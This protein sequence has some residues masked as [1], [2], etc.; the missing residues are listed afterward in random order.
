MFFKNR[1][2]AG[3]KLAEKL[4]KYKNIKNGIVLGLP[5]GG[6][7]VAYEV[8]QVL[9]LPLDI[10]VP[11]KVG[12]PGQPELAVGAVCEDGSVILNEALLQMANIKPEDLQ[13]IIDAEKQEAQ[14]RLTKYRRDR[15]KLDLKNKVV[16]LVDDGIATGS[17][18]R[19]AIASARAKGAEKIIVAVPVIPPDTIPVLQQEV[20]ELIYLDAP[21]YFGAVGAF[22]QNF[23]QT[24]DEEVVS[25]ME[26]A[27]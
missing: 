20:D 22:Y 8:A 24:P 7:P 25:L 16:I 1:V 27:R 15:P 14:R 2:D 13:P 23:G 26:E 5:R 10:V 3:K 19:A 12:M 17:T 21:V 9:N 4:I 6:V 18:M 11:R